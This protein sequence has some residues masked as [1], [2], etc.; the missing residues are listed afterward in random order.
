MS[1]V[2][3]V[4]AGLERWATGCV[5]LAANLISNLAAAPG[6]GPSN[7]STSSAVSAAHSKVAGVVSVLAGRLRST[8]GKYSPRGY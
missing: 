2:R 4:D 6:T 3:V 8:G 7:Q 5:T 1:D